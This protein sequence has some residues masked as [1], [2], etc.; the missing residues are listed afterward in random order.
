MHTYHTHTHTH[1][2]THI[3]IHGMI[4]GFTSPK[5]MLR[6]A[7]PEN[8]ASTSMYRYVLKGSD[9]NARRSAST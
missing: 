2:H 6:A 7:A 1:T 4:D 3:Y 8:H 9:R 5:G